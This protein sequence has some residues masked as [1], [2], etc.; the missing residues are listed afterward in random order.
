MQTNYYLGGPACAIAAGPGLRLWL[1]AR[2]ANKMLAERLALQV[3]PALSDAH[4]AA[5]QDTSIAIA[6]AIGIPK[7]EIEQREFIEVYP[8]ALSLPPE[9]VARSRYAVEEAAKRL[10]QFENHQALYAEVTLAALRD[11]IAPGRPK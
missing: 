1:K 2:R 3:Y 9:L 6:R 11:K 8:F 5:V 10:R 4:A 7:I